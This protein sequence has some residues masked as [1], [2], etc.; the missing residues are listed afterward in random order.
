MSH[1]LKIKQID[2]AGLGGQ[3]FESNLVV[4]LPAGK[5]FGRF[6]NGQTIEAAGLTAN[7]VIQLALVEALN[8]TVG[9]TSST[10][11]NFNDTNPSIVLNRIGTILSGGASLA[12]ASIDR[13]RNNTG[14]WVNVGTFGTPASPPSFTD[15]F[16]DTPFNTA[17]INYRYVLTDTAGGS[18][19]ATLNFT[20]TYVQPTISL[21]VTASSSSSPETSLSR[22]KGNVSSS[23][24][25][26]ITRNSPLVN[27]TSAVFQY[28]K[29]GA[30]DWIDI[31]SPSSISG[32]SASIGPITHN[33]SALED[34][35]S[36]SYRIK[37]I[38]TYQTHLGS[39]QSV[40]GGNTTVN[41]N[42]LIFYGPAASAPTSSS[43]IRALGTKIFANG[44]NPFNLLTGTTQRIFTVALPSPKTITN[45]IDLDANNAPLTNSYI[46]SLIAVNDGGGNSTTYNV[47]TM[48]NAIAY[49]DGSHRHQITRS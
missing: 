8:P 49:P 6:V 30:G 47:Y 31:G 14:N 27:L 20:P 22:E 5:S 18:S 29:N 15:T 17:T 26:T 43:A 7:E 44:A 42:N 9:L 1:K 12:T 10:T 33:D 35:D 34:S 36:I 38:D 45:V 24:S 48:T 37:V 4:Q 39:G 40:T 41:F 25:G 19:T 16:T 2:G 13:R 3:P 46:S 21:A 32:S 28:Q 23:L 11:V